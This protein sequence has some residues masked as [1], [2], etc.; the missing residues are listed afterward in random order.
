MRTYKNTIEIKAPVQRVYNFLI[1]PT[2]LPGIWPAMVSV[3]NMVPGT[4]GAQ[5]FDWVFKMAG[6]PFHGRTKFEEVQPGKFVRVRT[7]GGIL[8]TMRWTYEGL[9]GSG[10]RLTLEADYTIPTPIIGKI[11]EAL[12]AK[13]HE[14]D[15][16]AMLANLKDVMEGTGPTLAAGA[17]AH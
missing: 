15:T 13:I 17:H 7:E 8:S 9:D 12:V 3:S 4:G 14:R 2:N 5:D 10:T 1:Q 6:V 11:E 16:D